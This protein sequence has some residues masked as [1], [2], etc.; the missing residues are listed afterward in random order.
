MG[1]RPNIST[2]DNIFMVWQIFEKCHEY[3]ME[4]R[5]IFIDYVQAFYSVNRNRIIECLTEYEVPNKLIKLTGLT[6][7]N[8]TA[9][10]KIGN[11]YSNELKIVTGV[12]LGDPLYATL[13][14]ILIDNVI[15]Q[16]EIKGN[17]STCLVQCSAY[18]DYILVI[19]R[20]THA[21][22][23]TCH[24]LI[25]TSSQ[26]G[27][28]INEHKTKYLRCTKKQCRMDGIDSTNSHFEKVKSF[29]YLGSYVNGNSSIEEEIKERISMGNKAY[30]ANK[31]LFRSRLLTKY[32]KLR[33]YQTLVRAVVTYACETW[34][35]KE[36]I[37]MKLRVFERKILRRIFWPCQ[38][39]GR[40]TAG[41]NE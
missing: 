6:I 29:K 9:K 15:K 8:V 3:N 33:M 13:F 36:N 28:T 18:A 32:S 7:Q 40:H 2:I 31:D 4:L 35:L 30:Y 1:F 24:K 27:L 37:K 21:L 5:S 11:Y 19:A 22:T 26:V 10:V 14:S 34:V 16:L 41:Q 23:D 25:E 39:E 38:K 17:I 20:T 12:K